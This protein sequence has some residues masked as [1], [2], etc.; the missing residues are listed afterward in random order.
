MTEEWKSLTDAEKEQYVRQSNNEKS[1]YE[2]QMQAYKVVK[3]AE[4]AK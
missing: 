4:V 1:R 3:A 2:G